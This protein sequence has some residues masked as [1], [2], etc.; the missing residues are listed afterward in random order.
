MQGWGTIIVIDNNGCIAPPPENERFWWV[1]HTLDLNPP[2]HHD[3]SRSYLPTSLWILCF[4]G[5]CQ[6]QSHPNTPALFHQ[7]KRNRYISYLLVSH[8]HGIYELRVAE[9]QVWWKVL[10]CYVVVTL[11]VLH[12][13]Y[14]V[15][16]A[17]W[18]FNALPL[19]RH[20]HLM[21]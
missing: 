13:Q 19:L 6:C 5:W 8:H 18:S 20:Q 21:P 7:C 17:F 16:D 2:H 3:S 11:M 9:N 4:F 10:F 14:F 12:M 15:W 1:G